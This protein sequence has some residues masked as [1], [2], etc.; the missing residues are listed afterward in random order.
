VVEAIEAARK[1]PSV[2]VSASAIGYYG[3]RGDEV[4]TEQSPP[5][6]GFLPEVCVEWER[7]A[8]AAARLGVRVALLRI[9]IVLGP[10]GGM[11]KSVLPPFKAGLGGRLGSGKQWMSWIHLDDL[12]GMIVFAIEDA[13]VN[14]PV[15]AVAPQ[16]VR[17]SDFTLA[18][19]HTVHRPAVFPV[20]LFALKLRFGEMAEVIL[21]SQR[22]SPEA[23]TSAGFRYRYPSLDEALAGSM[24]QA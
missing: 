4:L 15:N 21:E 8:Q 3:S 19:A 5:G 18:V 12:A 22:V 7:E 20:P 14:G 9:G 16:P 1:R 17:N 6:S 10:G 23:A 2:L 13:R 11:L 24:I